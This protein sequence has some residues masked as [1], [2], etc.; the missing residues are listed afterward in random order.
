MNS[1]VGISPGEGIGY[2]GQYSYAS[3]VAQTVKNLPKMQETWVRSLA[4]EDPLVMGTPTPVF[5]PGEFHEHK[6]LSGYNPWSAKDLDTT[7]QLSLSS[8]KSHPLP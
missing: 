1:W 7:E 6:S 4:W 8:G 5:L 3:L 2:S